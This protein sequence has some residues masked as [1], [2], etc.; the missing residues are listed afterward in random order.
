MTDPVADARSKG[1]A[2]GSSGLCLND[3]L[4]LQSHV[5]VAGTLDASD[6]HLFF[7]AI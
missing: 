5:V 1:R 7:D 3:T 2:L 6:F 4:I